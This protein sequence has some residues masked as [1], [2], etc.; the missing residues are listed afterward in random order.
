MSTVLYDSKTLQQVS[1]I[2]MLLAP[3]KRK[4][5]TKQKTNQN[6]PRSEPKKDKVAFELVNVKGFFRT[7]SES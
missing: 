3:K 2:V 7:I 1:N 6:P 5:N 4:K